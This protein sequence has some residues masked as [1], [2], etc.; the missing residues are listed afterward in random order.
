MATLIPCP[1]GNS[2]QC[3]NLDLVVSLPCPSC[4]RELEVEFVDAQRRRQRLLLVQSD[5]PRM[6]AP[7][8]ILPI[9]DELLIGSN[10]Q[11]WMLLP[12]AQVAGVHCRLRADAAGTVRL[13]DFNTPAGTWVDDA[14]VVRGELRP[15]Q[16]LRIGGYAFCLQVE[17]VEQARVERNTARRERQQAAANPPPPQRI[18]ATSGAARTLTARR[19]A[20]SRLLTVV[21][22]WVAALYHYGQFGEA[23]PMEAAYVAALCIVGGVAFSLIAQRMSLARPGWNLAA[24]IVPGFLG[25][26]DTALI[27]PAPTV[28]AAAV[29]WF[30]LTMCQRHAPPPRQAVAASVIAAITTLVLA[31]VTVMTLAGGK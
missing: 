14:R 19:F 13:E 21:F 17:D 5:G 28:A 29:C 22:G 12:D 15:G 23:M 9:N 20:L 4:G 24:A 30:N 10:G 26:V 11:R 3:A 8:F 2:V 27:Q 31:V 6:T 7:Q 18:V 25:I 16:Q 1:C